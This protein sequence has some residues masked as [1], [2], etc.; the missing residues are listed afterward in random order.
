MVDYGKY[1][2]VEAVEAYCNSQPLVIKRLLDV[3]WISG[4]FRLDHEGLE[5]I[6]QAYRDSR[7]MSST[8]NTDN[9][10]TATNVCSISA[11]SSPS[12]SLR[13][14]NTTK[15]A[16]T[17][18]S[19]TTNLRTTTATT[20]NK[21]DEHTPDKQRDEGH[22]LVPFSSIKHWIT[23]SMCC[24]L[25]RRNM[26]AKYISKTTVGIA[27][28]LYFCCGSEICQ[29]RTTNKMEIRSIRQPI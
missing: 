25:C 28:E 26:K 27:T 13:Q 10:I 16:S 23:S 20:G 19:P 7:E 24:R 21:E 22:I 2:T 15:A 6:L 17:S 12:K 11:S 3:P 9:R 18:S 4:T 29:S 1:N 5:L 14:T 8:V